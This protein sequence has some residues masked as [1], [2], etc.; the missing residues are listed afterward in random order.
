MGG[1]D[2]LEARCRVEGVGRGGVLGSQG[3]KGGLGSLALGLGCIVGAADVGELVA[4]SAR[5]DVGVDKIFGK[6]ID[7]LTGSIGQVS[8]ACLYIHR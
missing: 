3:F 6:V 8:G 4:D 5:D 1:S 2:R 7:D